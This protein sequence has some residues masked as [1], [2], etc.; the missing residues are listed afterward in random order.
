MRM[1]AGLPEAKG[2]AALCRLVRFEKSSQLSKA[3][4]T[5]LLFR[6]KARRSALSRRRRGH[7]QKLAGL[8][9]PRR[10]LALDLGA[11]GRRPAGRNGEVA[12]TRRRRDGRAAADARGIEPRDRGPTDPLPGGLAAEARQERAGDRGDR[13]TRRVG[14][15]RLQF[16]GRPARLVDRPEGVEGGRSAERAAWAAVRR[17]ASAALHAGPG[18]RRARREA[19]GGGDGPARAATAP[20]QTGGRSGSNIAGWRSNSTIAACSTGRGAS[21]NT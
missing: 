20:R 4:A 13:P 2:V 5:A 12:K 14:A 7:S 21:T 18:L 15:E 9:T 16:R 6:G 8:P 3:A 11:A 17:R 1:L 10:R 19:A